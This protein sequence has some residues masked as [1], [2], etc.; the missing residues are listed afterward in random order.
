MNVGE[1]GRGTGLIMTYDV[2]IIS[3]GD[4]EA[5][6]AAQVRPY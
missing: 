2:L 1:R 3:D 6:V 5:G 4:E